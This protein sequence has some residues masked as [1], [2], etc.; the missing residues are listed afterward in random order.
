[1]SIKTMRLTLSGED[2]LPDIV[3]LERRV[4]ILT[5]L[6]RD[7]ATPAGLP[8]QQLPIFGH[9]RLYARIAVRLCHY[10]RLGGCVRRSLAI[11]NVC[12]SL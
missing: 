7:P 9:E 8:S 6:A 12:Y 3:C 11:D 5:I 10:L 4:H 2:G 1:M